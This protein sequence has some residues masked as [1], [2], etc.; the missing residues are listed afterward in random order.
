LAWTEE[1]VCDL[2]ALKLAD[3]DIDMEVRVLKVRQPRVQEGL[4]R[5]RVVMSGD[6]PHPKIMKSAFIYTTPF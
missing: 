6:A 5:T 4:F 1:T 3:L 2:F